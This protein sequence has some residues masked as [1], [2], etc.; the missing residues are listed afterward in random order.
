MVAHWSMVRV[1]EGTGCPPTVSVPAKLVFK[2]ISSVGAVLQ[3]DACEG[4]EQRGR[5]SHLRRR[6]WLDLI[7]YRRTRSVCSPR[8]A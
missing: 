5:T 3:S 2:G 1:P 4:D 6:K 7:L 8:V